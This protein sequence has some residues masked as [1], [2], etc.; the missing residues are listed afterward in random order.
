[1]KLSKITLKLLSTNAIMSLVQFVL[2]L[3][4]LGILEDNWIYQWAIG[5][6]FVAIFWFIVYVEMSE[7][8]LEDTKLDSYYPFRG[9][10]AGLFCSIPG[11]LL[12][13][14]TLIFP[15][16]PNW[17][18]IAMRIWLSQ[19]IKI[20]NSFES[21]MPHLGLIT[22]LLLPIV[23]GISYMDGPRKRQKVLNAIRKADEMKHEKSK[24]G[25]KK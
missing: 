8:G 22:S 21:Y 1:M 7:N 18:N 11:V 2:M 9:F 15:A 24:V 4:L 13:V 5:L 6:L 23:S 3:P 20:F 25:F 14:L 10:I 16:D 12:Y 19:Y 17:F